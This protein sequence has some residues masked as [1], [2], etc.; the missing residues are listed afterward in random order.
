MSLIG[1]DSDYILQNYLYEQALKEVPV[2]NQ[3]L[4]LSYETEV[5]NYAEKLNKYNEVTLRN[6]EQEHRDYLELLKLTRSPMSDVKS[7]KKLLSLRLNEASKPTLYRGTPPITQGISEQYLEYYL[8]GMYGE[9]LLPRNTTVTYNKEEV[10]R[11]YIPDFVLCFEDDSIIIDVEI[12]EPYVASSHE[13]IHYLKDLN[14]KKRRYSRNFVDTDFRHV[15]ELR[16]AFFLEKG[17]IVIRFT[18]KQVIYQPWICLGLIDLVV[19]YL[20]QVPAGSEYPTSDVVI[21]SEKM[22]TQ[23][24]A[25]RMASENYRNSYLPPKLS[26]AATEARKLYL[27]NN[28]VVGGYSSDDDNDLPF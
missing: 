4:K 24:A 17:W 8:Q 27:R 5:K 11:P 23:W 2:L 20:K 12:D 26:Q 22:W 28:E 18:E 19:D 13:P 25:V 7:R 1:L 21:E 6:Y 10:Q 15:D 9:K 14:E 3:H 16:D